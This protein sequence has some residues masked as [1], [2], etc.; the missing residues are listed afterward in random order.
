MFNESGV[1]ENQ[2]EIHQ[3]GCFF[4]WKEWKDLDYYLEKALK[5]LEGLSTVEL[6]NYNP[7]IR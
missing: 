6:V 4:L 5:C 7:L 1:Y 3:R 2:T